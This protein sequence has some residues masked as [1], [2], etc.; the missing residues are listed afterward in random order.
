MDNMMPM[1]LDLAQKAQASDSYQT[2]KAASSLFHNDQKRASHRAT[3]K[4]EPDVTEAVR[5]R[6]QQRLWQ[7]LLADEGSADENTSS[8][9]E[10]NTTRR[11]RPI[12]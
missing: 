10:Q 9:K 11:R 7:L 4:C 5:R 12:K 8:D 3:T 1:I 6:F 2:E